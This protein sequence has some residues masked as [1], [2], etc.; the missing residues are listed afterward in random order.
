MKRI[1]LTSP[2]PRESTLPYSEF[3]YQIKEKVY[4][5]EP[6]VLIDSFVIDVLTSRRSR[7]TF[8]TVSAEKLN[9]LLWHSARVICL[10]PPVASRWQHRSYPSAGG[11]HPI[12]L[13]VFIGR[14]GSENVLLYDP[15]AHGLS[16]VVI[17][18]GAYFTQLLD[19]TNQVVPLEEATIIWLG[20]QFER[21]LS[22]Y[23]NGE[24]LVWR[25]AGA[26][27]ATISL[28]AESLGL[29]CCA[30][31]ITGEPFLSQ[32]LNSRGKVVGVGGVLIGERA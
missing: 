18:E 21:T 5:S 6:N 26:L 9:A 4:L 25:D 27:I 8:K 15:L 3:K 22:K 20:A 31:G 30:L 28:V 23:E 24:S 7:R 11:L 2:I 29:N 32:M 13:L 1:D 14:E 10:T 17:N 19:L 16:K 12:D